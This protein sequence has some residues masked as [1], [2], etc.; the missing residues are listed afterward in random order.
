MIFEMACYRG[1]MVWLDGQTSKTRWGCAAE[2]NTLT[3]NDLQIGPHK[4][5]KIEVIGEPH[6]DCYPER[7][8]YYVFDAALVPKEIELRTADGT[9]RGPVTEVVAG[10]EN[11]EKSV[12]LANGENYDID[13]ITL[14]L[15][16]ILQPVG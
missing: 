6:D 7:G 5:Q 14:Y 15:K 16:A 13:E 4:V 8:S 1:T 9:W 12:R 10:S 2:G 11:E 3:T